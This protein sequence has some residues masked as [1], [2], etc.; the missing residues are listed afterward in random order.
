[1]SKQ[2]ISA[3]SLL[4]SHAPIYP[5]PCTNRDPASGERELGRYRRDS[6]Y[7][8]RRG[9]LFFSFGANVRAILVHP[10][11]VW[12]KYVPS[13]GLKASLQVYL[14]HLPLK[15]GRQRPVGRP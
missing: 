12:G 3:P 7:S 15:L 2:R 10:G 9:G 14:I 13:P 6:Y 1:M 5:E 11:L 4:P 8:A